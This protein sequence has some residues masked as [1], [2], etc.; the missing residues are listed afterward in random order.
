[1]ANNLLFRETPITTRYFPE[2][3]SI[4]FRR[5]VIYGIGILVVL[6]K[7][8]LHHAKFIRF[9]QFD[10][11]PIQIKSIKDPLKSAPAAISND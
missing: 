5:S 2:A 10:A 9:R 4:N 6:I 1:M 3:S 7:Y 11:K 8:F